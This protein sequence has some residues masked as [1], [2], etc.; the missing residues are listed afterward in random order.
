MLSG[1][2]SDEIPESKSEILRMKKTSELKEINAK[3]CLF[4]E[5][6]K[7]ECSLAKTP[8]SI[9]FSYDLQPQ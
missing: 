5:W 3:L 4:Q 1:S 6:Q 2:A 8:L 9:E 7:Q